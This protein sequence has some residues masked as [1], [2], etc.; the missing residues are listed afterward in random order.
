MTLQQE[1]RNE[2]IHYKT[3]AAK[4]RQTTLYIAY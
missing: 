2:P 3:Q 4:I 1:P